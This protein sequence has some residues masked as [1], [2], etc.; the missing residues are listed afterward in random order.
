[1]MRRLVPPRV[2]AECGGPHGI[3]MCDAD[4]APHLVPL[5]IQPHNGLYRGTL[6]VRVLPQGVSGSK[7]FKMEWGGKPEKG[8]AVQSRTALLR[9]MESQARGADYNRRKQV[10]KHGHTFTEA[11]TYTDG[12]GKR[13]CRT[14]M[15]ARRR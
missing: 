3:E 6:P 13:K 7:E 10:C 4:H 14:C 15:K 8:H 9:R 1:M 11:N 2:C 12:E 5:E